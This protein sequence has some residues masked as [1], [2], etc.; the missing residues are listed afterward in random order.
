MVGSTVYGAITVTVNV[1]NSDSG[2]GERNK[3]VGDEVGDD[4]LN[5]AELSHTWH[6]IYSLKTAKST[7]ALI[8]IRSSS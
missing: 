3:I 4:G 7:N 1:S 6:V 2:G 8:N 5:I